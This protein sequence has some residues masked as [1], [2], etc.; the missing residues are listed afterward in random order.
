M[1]KWLDSIEKYPEALKPVFM[2]R[3]ANSHV[4]LYQGQIVLHQLSESFSGIG[5]VLVEWYPTP[6]ISFNSKFENAGPHDFLGEAHIELVDAWKNKLVQVDVQ[7]MR[8]SS[9]Q[10][11]TDVTGVIDCWR[12]NVETKVQR[13][14]FHL[15]NFLPFR[16]EAIRDG[17]SVWTGR[18]EL[19]F[20]DWNIEIDSINEKRLLTEL[21]ATGGFGIT[22]VASLTRKD[23][24]TFPM[25]AVEN[26]LRGLSSF[27]SFCNG[28]WTGPFLQIGYDDN[29][30]PCCHVWEIPRTTPNRTVPRWFSCLRLNVAKDLCPGF[31]QRWIDDTWR[32]TIESTVYWYI[33][34]NAPGVAIENGVIL[35]NVAFET[36]GWTLFVQ[37]KRAISKSGYE[38]L[39]AA[40]K[41]RLLLD[42]CRIDIDVPSE[43]TSLEAAAKAENWDGASALTA[44]RNAYIHPSPNNREKLSRVGIEAQH[45]AWFLSMYYVE[46]ILLFLCGYHG[47][48]SNRLIGDVYT[49]QEV[50]PVPW[51]SDD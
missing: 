28:R 40:D 47:E 35:A 32:E 30:R 2:T 5:K 1:K 9:S 46:L 6:R 15:P 22:H 20:G 26:T 7:S 49:G 37:D 31:A 42:H 34:G 8:M 29:S 18:T 13:V 17:L 11:S 43:L 44:I 24:N 14:I 38:R 27:L 21:K 45:E 4:E 39:E 19:K 25:D 3:H 41:L 33:L 36:L 48:Y 12:H 16:G 10:E 23:G 50:M 51:V